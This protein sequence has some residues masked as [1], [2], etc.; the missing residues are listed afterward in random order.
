MARAAALWRQ[1]RRDCRARAR[2]GCWMS[3]RAAQRR[4]GR[5]RRLCWQRWAPAPAGWLP[6]GGGAKARHRSGPSGPL[7][8]RSSVAGLMLNGSGPAD[9][10]LGGSAGSRSSRPS[11]PPSSIRYH[12]VMLHA[13]RAQVDRAIAALHNAPPM[14][15]VDCTGAGAGL[16]NLLWSVAGSSRTLIAA[17]FPY[18]GRAVAQLIGR[19]PQQFCSQDTA[20]ALAAAGYL[21]AQRCL[22]E[23]GRFSTPII[24][25]GLTAAVS[26]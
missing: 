11:T 26:T 3:N 16:F 6:T 14:A 10:P 7:H 21:K 8:P 20:I 18:D 1:P 13:D 24:A 12:A 19:E 23:Q 5:W 2:A 25:V 4:A 17:E 22:V 9:S 15:Y